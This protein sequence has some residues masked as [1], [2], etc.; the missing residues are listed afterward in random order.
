MPDAP[1]SQ[2]GASADADLPGGARCA[3]SS[4]TFSGREHRQPILGIRSARM[5]ASAILPVQRA[6]SEI[7]GFPTVTRN[8]DHETGLLGYSAPGLI[9]TI[10]ACSMP[11]QDS[12]H[13]VS[14]L[15]FSTRYFPAYAVIV[16]SA[17]RRSERYAR[18]RPARQAP[19]NRNRQRQLWS[20]P[21]RVTPSF[22]P[23][24][25]PSANPQPCR[26]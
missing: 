5:Q 18:P 20:S 24:P 13:D 3:S 16:L 15:S 14:I 21:C 19:I 8:A 2:A 26:E 17:R 25:H 23:L 4:A 7:G 11:F 6:H 1:E 10:R 22:L 9:V 12:F